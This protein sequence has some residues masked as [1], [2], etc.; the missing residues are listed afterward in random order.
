MRKSKSFTL[1]ELIVIVVILGVLAGLAVPQFTTA[2][3]RARVGKAEHHLSL[4][5]QAQKMCR[6]DQG[7]YVNFGIHDNPHNVAC[8]GLNL[9]DYIELHELDADGEWDYSEITGGGATFTLNASRDGG[10]H[11]GT[12]ITL[13]QNGAWGGSHPL[14]PNPN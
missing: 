5:A 14:G 12:N 10:S 2:L 13:N 1:V 8:G 11:A 3:E 6:L 9:G 4:L 7:N